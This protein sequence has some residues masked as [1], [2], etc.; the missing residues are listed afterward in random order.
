MEGIIIEGD[1]NIRAKAGSWATLRVIL[2]QN[3]GS[4]R[5]KRVKLLYPCGRFGKFVSQYIRDL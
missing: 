2:E 5:L 4:I 3:S 1:K